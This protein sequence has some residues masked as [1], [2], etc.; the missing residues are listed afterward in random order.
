MEPSF[1]ALP[2]HQQRLQTLAAK[3]LLPLCEIHWPKVL[4]NG[5]L[6]HVLE[7]GSS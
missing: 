2:Q 4:V 1:I 3:H 7:V 6:Q 5:T